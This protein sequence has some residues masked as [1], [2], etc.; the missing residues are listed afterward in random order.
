[1]K[2][3][4]L[5]LMLFVVVGRLSA[6]ADP[7]AGPDSM[8][9]MPSLATVV[10]YAVAHHPV[11]QRDQASVRRSEAELNSVQ[12]RWL[13]GLS[14]DA[15]FQWGSYG[16]QTVNTLLLGSRVGVTVRL[17]LWDILSQGDENEQYEAILEAAKHTV[18]VGW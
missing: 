6:Q 11:V 17:S 13:D 3:Q 1:M 2:S 15:G 4:S 14:L 18:T 7:A 5:I 9:T 8:K 10:K 12:K 16:D